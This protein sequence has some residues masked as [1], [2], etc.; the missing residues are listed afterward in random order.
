MITYLL[1][2]GLDKVL[3]KLGEETAETIIAAKNRDNAELR[4]ESADLLFHLV[5]LL[6]AR[7]VAWSDVMQELARRH[8]SA[9]TGAG[10]G[11]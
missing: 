7:G 1:E 4:S 6:H 3:K 11:P 10:T 2:K 8:Q 9:S 5:V